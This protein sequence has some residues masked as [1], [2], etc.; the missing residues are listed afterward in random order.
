MKNL[1]KK[2]SAKLSSTTEEV[3]KTADA[4][5]GNHTKVYVP[6]IESF[7]A[8]LEI[9]KVADEAVAQHLS[10]LT[11][12]FSK[13]T[14]ATNEAI[15]Q[16]QE[17]LTTVTDALKTTGL[18]AGEGSEKAFTHLSGVDDSAN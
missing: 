6:T 11:S 5:L 16:H 9:K 7:K 12:T 18:L 3:K 14:K 1:Q 15:G 17:T 8:A 13:N 4:A 10:T 2:L